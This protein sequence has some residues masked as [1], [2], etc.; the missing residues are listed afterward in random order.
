MSTDDI[1]I[2]SPS[3]TS[4][5]SISSNTNASSSCTALSHPIPSNKTVSSSSSLNSISYSSERI[6]NLLKYETQQYCI[7]DNDASSAVAAYWSTFGFPAELNKETGDFE[8][9]MGFTSCRKCKKTFAYG[10]HS[11]TSHMKQHPC[12]I[13]CM[14]TST[15]S[16]VKQTSIDKIMKTRKTLTSEQTNV[17]KD[18]I[19]RWVCSDI[20]PVSIIE[21]DGLRALIQEC[22]KLGM[23][24]IFYL[25]S[26]EYIF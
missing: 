13:D 8:R 10:P 1:F 24:L 11:G 19:V 15:Q 23:Y 17:I 4:S 12:L 6:H 5:I 26:L 21:D 20:R 16:Q 9:I 14:K 7:I 22:V 2:L 3:S 25:I 18:L